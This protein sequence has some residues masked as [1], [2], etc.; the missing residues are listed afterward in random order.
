MELPDGTLEL[1]SLPPAQRVP[2]AEGAARVGKGADEILVLEGSC[3]VA[4]A[5]WRGIVVAGL[6]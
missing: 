3:A 1:F 4:L 5:F 6:I 2:A